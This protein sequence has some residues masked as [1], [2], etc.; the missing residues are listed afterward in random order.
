[1]TSYKVVILSARA[2]NLVPCVR[3]LQAMEPDL[4]P[5]HVVVV[6]DGARSEAEPALPGLCWV[7]GA[8]PFVFARNANLGI[9]AADSDVV[10]LN[11]DAL[12][13]TPRGLTTMVEAVRQRPELGLCSPAVKGVVG[14]D[15]QRWYPGAA[16]LREEPTAL[17]FVCVLI[18]REVYARVGPLDERFV[19]YGYDDNDYSDRVRA[20]GLRLGVW[21]DTVVEHGSLA[22]TFR[23]RADIRKITL[24]N[25]KLYQATRP[26]RTPEDEGT[27]PAAAGTRPR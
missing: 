10:L 5:D 22:S 6:D 8:K 9:A 4:P 16:G 14:N 23:T 21:H 12:L 3:A 18:P 27:P 20:T 11:D 17:M 2:S 26:P 25:F 15:R 19:G 24:D 7:Q 13:Q 1:M